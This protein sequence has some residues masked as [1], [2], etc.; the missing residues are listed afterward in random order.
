MAKVEFSAAFNF[1]QRRKPQ[2]FKPVIAAGSFFA[3]RLILKT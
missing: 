1:K 2:Y 3:R